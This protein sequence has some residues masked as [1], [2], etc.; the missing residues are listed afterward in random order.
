MVYLRR[1]LLEKDVYVMLALI[2]LLVSIGID[3]CQSLA[4]SRFPGAYP[5]RA[6]R[7]SRVFSIL[8]GVA[9]SVITVVI[10]L[11]SGDGLR[12]SVPTLLMGAANGVALTAYNQLLL[13]ASGT[14]PYSLVMLFMLAGGICCPLLWNLARGVALAPLQWIG[15][16]VMLTAFLLLNLPERG[17]R[18]VSG[19]FLLTCAA[20]FCANGMYGILL[21]AQQ[22]M[23][24]NTENAG[25]IIVT[26]GMSAVLSVFLLL[27][28]RDAG[29]LRGDFRLTPTAAMWATASSLC[30]ACAVNLL[31]LLLGMLPAAVVY[32]VTNGGVLLCSTAISILF[33]HETPTRR[34]IVGLA[35]GLCAVVLLS[36]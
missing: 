11:V 18:R 36:I 20:L 22:R 13:R 35:V 12:F 16:A 29:G 14:G 23:M 28:G 32:A 8:Y 9:V 27:P 6:E 15:I 10:S 7:S 24:Q 19:A 5:G 1:I 34:R 2:L 26:Y 31:M 25:M 3:T 17:E 21:D 4:A 30:A 33:L